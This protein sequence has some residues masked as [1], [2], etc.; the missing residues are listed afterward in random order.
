MKDLRRALLSYIQS[1]TSAIT[2]EV[3]LSPHAKIYIS[4]RPLKVLE[5]LRK[6][7]AHATS[8]ALS[9]AEAN[10]KVVTEEAA[11]LYAIRERFALAKRYTLIMGLSWPR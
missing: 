2:G 7:V 4:A 6:E 5:L 11:R 8:V 3:Y 9:A 1:E 10:L